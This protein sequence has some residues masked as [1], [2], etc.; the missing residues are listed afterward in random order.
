MDSSPW[1]CRL[2]VYPAGESVINQSSDPDEAV[3]PQITIESDGVVGA[4]AGLDDVEEV[5]VE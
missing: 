5:F 3:R 1:C 2:G 4:S